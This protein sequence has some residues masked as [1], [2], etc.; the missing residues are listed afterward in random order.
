MKFKF[1]K[2]L[3]HQI[4]A[5]RSI[6]D[7]LDTSAFFSGTKAT[8]FEL[9]SIG[10][11]LFNDF[12][13]GKEEREIILKNLKDIQKRNGIEL[14]DS[15]G[16]LD[17]SVEMETGTGKTYV[18]LRT[19]FELNQKY[20]LKKFIILVPSVAI[21]EGV[22]KTIEQTKEHFRELY[23]TGFVSFAYDSEKLSQVREFVQ[24]F[25]LQIMIMTVQSFNHDTRVLRQT[26]DR[27]HGDKPIELIAETKPVVIMDEPQNMESDLAKEAIADLKPLFKL[28]YSA[29]HK[30][31]HNLVYRL[32]P[33][34][35]YKKG[36][37][38]KIAVYGV[39]EDDANSFIFKVLEIQTKKG[40][41]PKA[42]VQIEIKNA[43][44]DYEIKDIILR[45]GDDLFRKTKENAK[46]IGLDIM[47]V[48]AIK[49][50]VELSDGKFYYLE[51]E[52]E[53]KEDVFRAQIR[54]TIKA[55][56]DKQEELGEDVKVLSLFFIDH[57]HNYVYEKG[58][59]RQL[60]IEEFEKLKGN[61]AWFKKMDVSAVHKG[62]FA[63][64]KVKGVQEFQD[65]RGSTAI[66][67]DAYDLI[68][69]EKE[70]LLSFDEPVSFIF[71]HSALK[72]G[73]DN[74]NIFQ[75]CTLRETNSFMKKRQ[76]IGRGLRLAVNSKGDRIYDSEVNVLTVIAN[77]SYEGY[78]RGLQGEF[79]EAGYKEGIA[80]DN[81]RQK[82]V[83]VE[84][85]KRFES[86]DFKEL[87]SRIARKT[88]FKIE[89]STKKLIENVLVELND[90]DVSDPRIMVERGELRFDEKNEIQN[91]RKP[92]SAG[93]KIEV[94]VRLSDIVWRI[95][96][97]TKLTRKTV[98]DILSQSKTLDGLF[99][100]PEVYL[101]SFAT[102]I[103]HS[104]AKSLSGEGLKYIPTGD[105]WEVS[106]FKPFET[107]ESKSIPSERSVFDR[108]AYDSEGEKRFA[109][110]L[111]VSPN[112]ILYTKLP[113]DF[114]I[115][116]PVGE[117]VPDWAIVWDDGGKQKFYFVRETKFGYKDLE[118]QLRPDELA[119]TK[120]AEKH[121]KAIDVD[122][123]VVQRED[124]NDLI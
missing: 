89:I 23:N 31:I 6:V 57:V 84:H 88:K 71:S 52:S 47:D 17:F 50:R 54:E 99:R 105:M 119:K 97:E 66:D 72:E 62:Y 87:W 3:E 45:A 37:V 86:P 121:F 10:S 81:A 124:L 123:K 28:R 80:P 39:R 2:N 35:A 107:F 42:K 68:M 43:D 5:V 13:L 103:K 48:H 15:L 116:T 96:D 83:K 90:L 19:I 93:S 55:H 65:T 109:E 25:D 78:V 44:G 9:K 49:N 117:Y 34:D 11:V 1:S 74:P 22:L 69:K 120:A 102:I 82:R 95:A 14:S 32:T 46:Y 58:L 79:N 104:L 67:K 115:N 21:R 75:I 12:A 61:Y 91:V 77:D 76:E 85:T 92:G 40:E 98:F 108:I 73:W 106:L 20:G 53:N 41:N 33:V 110:S 114:R 118:N 16:E 63:S 26:P 122:F 112:V 94:N 101:R 70:R 64:K 18:Y 4:E 113:R 7:V 59:I 8:F 51:T 38:K 29:T 27:F 56:C 111:E 36:L 60:F 30:E 24:S 100:N